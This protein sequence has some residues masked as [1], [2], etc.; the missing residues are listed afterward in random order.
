MLQTDFR[1]APLHCGCRTAFPLAVLRMGF[2]FRLATEADA[3]GVSELIVGLAG[4]FAASSID[5]ISDRF[6]ASIG[7]KAVA[8]R[9]ASS[10]FHCFVAEDSEWLCGFAALRDPSHLFHLFVSARAQSQGLGRLLWKEVLRESSCSEISVNATVSAV[11]FYESLGFVRAAPDVIE[12]GI[13][14]A[15]MAFNVDS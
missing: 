4:F 3:H 1:F 7:E 6:M 9:F 2:S 10:Q 14:F 11:G 15:P 13:A 12:D 5:E 8:E